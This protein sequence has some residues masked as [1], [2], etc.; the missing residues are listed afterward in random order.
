MHFQDIIYV[1]SSGHYVKIVTTKGIHLPYLRLKDV[2]EKL[3]TDQFARINRHTIIALKRVQHFDLHTVI[4]DKVSFAF[5]DVYRQELEKRN[6]MLV[7]KRTTRERPY[8]V[9]P[10]L[11]KNNL[12]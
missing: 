2:E 7:W 11:V 12:S 8:T 3:P 5:S 6:C 10:I 1:L 4:V 9:D